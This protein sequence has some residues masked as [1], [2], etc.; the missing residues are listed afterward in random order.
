MTGQLDEFRWSG[1]PHCH[2]NQCAVMAEC[3]EEIKQCCKLSIVGII[4]SHLF[5]GF[6]ASLKVNCS[7]GTLLCLG[8]QTG[9]RSKIQRLPA[10][11]I[12]V[13]DMKPLSLNKSRSAV[14]VYLPASHKR[15]CQTIPSQLAVPQE[16]SGGRMKTVSGLESCVGGGHAIWPVADSQN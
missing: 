10:F 8:T 5:N 2:V 3:N 6:E 4:R 7:Q 15:G 14:T 1:L 12:G 11:C 13:Y 9:D 16:L